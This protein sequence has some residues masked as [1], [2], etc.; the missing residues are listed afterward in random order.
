MERLSGMHLSSAVRLA[1]FSNDGRRLLMV[2][3]DQVARVFDAVE[4]RQGEEPR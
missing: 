3:A 4:L 2:T 1:R